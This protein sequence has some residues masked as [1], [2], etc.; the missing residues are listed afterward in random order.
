[1]PRRE[2]KHCKHEIQ[3]HVSDSLHQM[4]ALG[5]LLEIDSLSFFFGGG[6]ISYSINIF[7]PS[8]AILKDLA[9]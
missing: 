9:H 1:M 6:G 8:G 5:Y 2:K 4:V 3:F 7:C